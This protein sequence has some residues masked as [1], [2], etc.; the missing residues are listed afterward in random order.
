[1]REN[2]VLV[3]PV[4]ILT[5]WCAGFTW[6]HDTLPCVLILHSVHGVIVVVLGVF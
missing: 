6:P 2:C 5:V 1:M 3:L 4:N